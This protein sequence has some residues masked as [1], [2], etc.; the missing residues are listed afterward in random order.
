[1]SLSHDFGALQAAYIANERAICEIKRTAPD[2]HLMMQNDIRLEQAQIYGH[3]KAMYPREVGAIIRAWKKEADAN[4]AVIVWFEE[5]AGQWTYVIYDKKGHPR[6]CGW[7]HET[8]DA[9]Y[10]AF[11][12]WY[13]RY[14]PKGYSL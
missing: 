8:F 4:R 7:P 13:E 11:T 1:M 9:C 10:A 2:G 6:D 12:V 14:T 3:V 5:D